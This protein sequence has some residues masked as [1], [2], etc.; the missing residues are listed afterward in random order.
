MLYQTEVLEWRKGR[1]RR[2]GKKQYSR[3]TMVEAISMSSPSGRVSGRSRR[4]AARRIREELFGGAAPPIK[5]KLPEQPDEAT[6]IRRRIAT[7]T[8]L[9]E[10]GMSPRKHMKEVRRLKERLDRLERCDE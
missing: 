2:M 9:A 3:D 4:A 7:L 8:E 6:F 1:P 10:R 5:S